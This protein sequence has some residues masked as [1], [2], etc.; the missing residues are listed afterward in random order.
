MSNAIEK[1]TKKLSPLTSQITH[2]PLYDDILSIADLQLFMREHVFAVWDFMCLLKELH[3]R[4]VSTS[5]PWIPPRDALS[6][7]LISSILV[8]EEGDVTEDGD[9]ASHFDIY[10]TAMEQIGADTWPINKLLSILMKGN[11]AQDKVQKVIRTLP[12]LS[13]TKDFVLT[14][15]SFFKRPVHELAA[16]FVY[17]REAITPSMFAPI[18]AYLESGKC[19]SKQQYST[20]RYYFKRHI[21]LD[22]SEHFPKA[23]KMLSNLIGEDDQKLKEA[24]DAAIL[25]LTARIEFFANVRRCLC[26]S[27]DDSDKSYSKQQEVFYGRQRLNIDYNEKHVGQ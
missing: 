12:I 7:N 25:A 21:E 19:S 24:E 13:S 22:D 17:G 9:Y 3:G 18:L 20:L 1:L 26:L 5:A 8:E 14:T 27:R 16:A 11:A 10:L 6:A 2:H 23:L 15:F 4:I